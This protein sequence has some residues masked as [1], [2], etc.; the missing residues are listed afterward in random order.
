MPSTKTLW[1]L[2]LQDL[3]EDPVIA[4]DGYTY[5]RAAI[6]NWIMRGK[7]S[8]MTNLPLPSNVLITNHSARGTADLLR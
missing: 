5:E 4:S 7:N 3:Y 1:S 6:A 2:I 8:P